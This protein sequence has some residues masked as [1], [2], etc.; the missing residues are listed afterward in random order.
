MDMN[1]SIYYRR[2]SKLSLWPLVAA[3]GLASFA[4]V[5]HI[6]VYYF[7][8]V[9]DVMPSVEESASPEVIASFLHAVNKIIISMSIWI[10]VLIILNA[11]FIYVVW[12]VKKLLAHVG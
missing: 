7:K 11:A 6:V 4:V 1:Q 9:P 10:F 2:L 8:H 12:N 3:V 5:S